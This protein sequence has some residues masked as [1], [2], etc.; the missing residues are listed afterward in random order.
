MPLLN[1]PR[2]LDLPQILSKYHI[3]TPQD[4]E[5]G[6]GRGSGGASGGSKRKAWKPAAGGKGQG[7]KAKK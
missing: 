1:R 2:K 4:D 7:K 6:G 5:G 3:N